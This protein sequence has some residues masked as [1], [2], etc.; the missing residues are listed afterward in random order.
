MPFNAI[1]REA[2][3]RGAEQWQPR[4]SGKPHPWIALLLGGSGRPLVFDNDTARALGQSVAQR[5]RSTG[6]TVLLSTSRRTPL[7]AADATIAALDAN[8]VIYRWR[9]NDPQNPYAAFLALAD[10]IVVTGDSASML[11][12]ALRSGKKVSVA[13]L[14]LQPDLRR[15]LV[16]GLRA[17]L[18]ASWFGLLVD[19]GLIAST[20]DLARLQA[21]LRREGLIAQ[22]GAD[23][24]GM[25]TL[26]DDLPQAAERLKRLLAARPGARVTA[27]PT[28]R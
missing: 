21:R 24:A 18:P 7:D 3:T 9:P 22:P 2:L 10:E 27:R 12:E 4:L 5:A 8:A 6:G 25:A 26:D 13:P 1:S 20:R 19:L 28:Q 15:R 11:A 17:V 16:D 14:P 23:T